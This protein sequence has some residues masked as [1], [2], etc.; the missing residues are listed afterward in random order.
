MA[1]LTNVSNKKALIID[2]MPDMRN[3][4]Q[5]TLTSLGFDKLHL[6]SSIKD[7][8]EKIDITRYDVILCDY[9]LGE[10]TNGQ[11]FLEYLRTHN[12]LER[13]CV[14]II[15][16]AEN[17]YESVASAAECLPD[18]YLLKPFTAGQFLSRFERLLERQEVL[19]PIDLAHDNKNGHKI[20]T[21]CNKILELKNKYYVDVCK[22]KAAALVR[23]GHTDEAIQLYNEVLQLRDLPWAQLGLARAQAKL[24]NM[25]ASE[26][27]SQKLM[28]T[29]PQFV[30]NFDFASEILMQDNKPEQALQVLKDAA[31]NSPGNMNRTRN[32]TA[33]AMAN[34]E[35]DMA[36]KLMAETIKKHKHSP[37]R[38]AADYALLSRA[39]IE[40]GKTKEAL[41][42]LKDAASQFNDPAS[43]VVLAA[44]NSLAHIKA[45]DVKEAEAALNQAL[46]EDTRLLAP[47]AA[48]SLAEA[49]FAAGKDD[50]A[51]DFLKQI[52]QNNPDDLRLQGRVKMV[53]TMA[54][55][56][57][58]EV[59]TLIQ[60]SAK[61]IIKINNDGVRK[62]QAGE[63][64]EA[65]EL[66]V[67]AAERLPNNL[68]IISNA[69]LILAVSVANSRNKDELVQCLDY[70]QKVMDK[71]P[72]HP[73]LA[74][75][76]MMLKKAKMTE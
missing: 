75:I 40:Q 14:F 54:G 38:E 32:L 50:L 62:A 15:I 47:S 1:T 57:T 4:L 12:K 59:A 2:D 10:S 35:F 41:S 17:S 33:L 48:A 20:I 55:K 37:L 28:Q 53:C 66:I 56:N 70:R 49:C 31:T 23:I 71:D 18:D 69:A 67:D 36:E 11:Q 65:I 24:G 74:Q 8:M 3:Q 60:E 76:D 58:D 43:K 72:V 9:N 6:A 19:R 29:N 22:I 5:M 46:A 73:K 30:A 27:I 68:N 42:S 64:K 51:S 26:E 44:S 61:E 34:G 21:E 13:N 45:G 63:Y 16:T 39:L 25:Q 7:A 52:L